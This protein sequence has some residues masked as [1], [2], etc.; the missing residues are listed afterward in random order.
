MP[1]SGFVCGLHPMGYSQSVN[2]LPVNFIQSTADKR[3]PQSGISGISEA[4]G[5]GEAEAARGLSPHL[6]EGRNLW[7]YLAAVWGL[8]CGGG[9][10]GEEGACCP[11]GL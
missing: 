6:S 8:S 10:G 1:V 5:G 7:R 3:R 9:A 11:R 2:L 4:C